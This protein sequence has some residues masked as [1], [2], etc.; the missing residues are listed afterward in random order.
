MTIDG[1]LLPSGFQSKRKEGRYVEF[2]ADG[3]LA[4]VGFYVN[5]E[6]RGWVLDLDPD[7]QTGRVEILERSRFT[8]PDEEETL[9]GETTSTESERLYI[10][11]VKTWIEEV[12]VAASDFEASI[13]VM[14]CSF[15]Q[16]RNEQ[17]RKMI[18]GPTNCI[19]NECIELCNQLLA[20]EGVYSP[21]G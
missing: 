5:G 15:C 3:S 11:W 9:G 16:K 18:A 21:L 6:P 12:E 10:E 14:R 4:H 17:V 20:E 13:P 2:H 7:H 1:A 8:Y 19:C